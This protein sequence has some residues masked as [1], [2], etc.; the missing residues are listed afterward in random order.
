MEKMIIRLRPHHAVALY[1]FADRQPDRDYADNLEEIHARL[2]SGEREMVQIIMHRDSLCAPCPHQVDA[3][4]ERE[5]WVQQ[6]DRSIA[7]ACSLKSGQ[8]LPWKDL[9]AMMDAHVF[10]QEKWQELCAAC[11]WY[12]LCREVHQKQTAK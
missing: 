6:L 10:E 12:D 9:C 3:A 2:S 5:N 4:C 1:H 11:Q 8:W 7:A